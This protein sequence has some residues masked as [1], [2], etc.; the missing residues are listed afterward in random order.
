VAGL[1]PELARAVA[2]E[3]ALQDQSG[4]YPPARLG[5][6][7]SHPGSFEAAHLL[8]D[9]EFWDHAE[10]L[11]DTVEV[12]DLVVVGAGISGLAAA[13]FWQQ[14]AGPR[15]KILVL[16]NHDDFGGHAKRNEFAMRGRPLLLN[17]GT[18]G[19]E[20]PTPYST[21]ADG[22]LRMLGVYPP[23]LA[24]DCDRSSVY[25]SRGLKPATYFDR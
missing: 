11:E 19:I 23:T 13:H 7:G 4:Y 18:L 9:G 5:L 2:A 1:A 21:V 25:E 14:G 16:D 20:S 12:Y 8:R 17:G 22:V 24:K 3:R 6:R 10:H 15:A